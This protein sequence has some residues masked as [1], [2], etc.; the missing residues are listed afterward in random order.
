KKAFTSDNF[1]LG[2]VESAELDM[3][4]WQITNFFIGL[5]DDAAKKIGFR[6][7]F[8][9]RVVICLPVSAIKTFQDTAILN[10]TIAE[11]QDLKEC[12]E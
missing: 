11:L 5:S 2:D 3:N 10:K 7:P 4:T 9:G 1:L 6:R 8:L 12:K